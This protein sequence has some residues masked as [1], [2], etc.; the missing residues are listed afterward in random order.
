MRDSNPARRPSALLAA[1][2][3]ALLLSLPVASC[4]QTDLIEGHL[5][6]SGVK[7]FKGS[8]VGLAI[9]FVPTDRSADLTQV[10]IQFDASNA[11]F[12]VDGVP[13][14][15]GCIS[16]PGSGRLSLPVNGALLTSDARVRVTAYRAAGS[17]F[18]FT[19]GAPGTSAGAA[20]T[21]GASVGGTGGSTAASTQPKCGGDA[22]DDALWP[23]VGASVPD[24]PMSAGGGGSGGQGSGGT[25]GTSGN[26]GWAGRSGEGGASGEAGMSARAGMGGDSGGAGS[27]LV[28][29]DGGMG[30]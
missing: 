20:A 29:G 1:S 16:L 13:S 5:F 8:T 17:S 19:A 24:P 25:S 27:A 28:A 12:L 23:S 4:T 18:F 10:Q 21:A 26:G 30:P 7:D 15:A 22:I 9:D 11:S 2:V 6:V 3:S 14:S